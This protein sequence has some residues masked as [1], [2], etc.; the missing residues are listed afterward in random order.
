MLRRAELYIASRRLEPPGEVRS[1]AGAWERALFHFGGDSETGNRDG[2]ATRS[3]RLHPSPSL[4]RTR[5][6]LGSGGVEKMAFSRRTR[7]LI[8]R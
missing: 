7:Y 5:I 6:G 2:C 4:H 1:Q 8:V 3:R